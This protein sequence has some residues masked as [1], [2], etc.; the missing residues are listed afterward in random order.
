MT[1]LHRYYKDHKD[2]INSSI[3]ELACDLA[4]ARLMNEHGQ[5]F[6]AF[7][8]PD[9]PDDPEGGTHYK[10]KFQD[11]FDR[12]YDEQYDRIARLMKFDLNADD[13]VA[14]DN[15][16]GGSEETESSELSPEHM[17]TTCPVSEEDRQQLD[18][19][20]EHYRTLGKQGLE[21]MRDIVSR[22]DE[23]EFSVEGYSVPVCDEDHDPCCVYG[24]SVKDGT[25]CASLDYDSGDIRE[26]PADSLR[27]G[28]IF[29]AFCELIE[30]L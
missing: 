3:I 14:H 20:K 23:E 25:L 21:L 18:K 19:L 1:N 17:E 11:E 2:D 9:D 6:E 26:V 7:V 30:N 15:A 27:I 4:A 10:E 24:F 8:E 13:G 22:F 12:Y 16:A 29:D 28:E 5:P